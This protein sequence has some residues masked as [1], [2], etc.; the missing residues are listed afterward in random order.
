[1]ERQSADIQ[2]RCA[3]CN[4]PVH[5][6]ARSTSSRTLATPHDLPPAKYVAAPPPV[7]A[8]P[9]N[10]SQ[11]GSVIGNS[12]E[13]ISQLGEGGM[14]A[15]YEARHIAMPKFYAVKILKQEL[16]NDPDFRL[17]FEQEAKTASILNHPHLVSIY[18]YGTTIDGESYLVMDFIAGHSLA[19]RLKTIKRIDQEEA[20]KIFMQICDCLSHA[21]G[22]GIIHRDLKPSNVMIVDL[23]QTVD[24]VKIVDFGIAKMASGAGGVAHITQAITKTGEFFGSPLYMSPEQG[25][26][27][28]IDLRSDIY[29]LGV[30]MYECL[31]SAPPFRGDHFFFTMMQHREAKPSPF[32]EALGIDKKLEKIVMK[33]LEKAP[34]DRYQTMDQLRLALAD[35]FAEAKPALTRSSPQVNEGAGAVAAVKGWVVAA[36]CLATLILLIGGAAYWLSGKKI[37]DQKSMAPPVV[38]TATVKPA[39]YAA[40]HPDILGE[41]PAIPDSVQLPEQDRGLDAK[42]LIKKGDQMLGSPANDWRNLLPARY[43]ITAIDLDPSLK[44]AYT[45][46]QEYYWRCR[47]KAPD[48]EKAAFLEDCIKVTDA[49]I[50]R[51]PGILDRYWSRCTYHVFQMDYDKALADVNMALTLAPKTADLH[52]KKGEILRSLHRY[53]EAIKE[54]EPCADG[55]NQGLLYLLG[56]CYTETRQIDKAISFCDKWL[57]KDPNVV[58]LLLIRGDCEMD[59]HQYENARRDY[60]RLRSISNGHQRDAQIYECWKQL[61]IQG[62]R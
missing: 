27:G 18:D 24:S 32:I 52:I 28:A 13:L 38:K 43:Y 54:L 47:E 29:S 7:P 53:D 48:H 60:L 5:A 17:R 62:N 16:N 34:D 56:T 11:V 23:N 50:K 61:G 46:L 40:A 8:Q 14:G 59:R 21:H 45:S 39:A 20:V 37:G 4:Q 1:M 49:S 15:V 44:S 12:Y 22:L 10:R 25:T 41:L 58:G 2:L 19:D 36:F 51:F 31:T 30:L 55:K 35:V 26:G 33:T 42:Q 57:K 6:C 9:T 3:T